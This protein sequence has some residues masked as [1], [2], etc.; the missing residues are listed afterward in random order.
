MSSQREQHQ[1]SGG[2]Q[3]HDLVHHAGAVVR[4]QMLFADV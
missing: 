2:V 3:V 1:V 4:G